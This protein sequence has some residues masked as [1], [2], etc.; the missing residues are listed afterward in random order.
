VRSI[1]LGFAFLVL[2]SSARTAHGQT[3]ELLGS[4]GPTIVDAGN[5]FTVGAAVSPGSRTSFV[6]S[7]ERTHLSSREGFNERSA[8][9]FRGGT[10]LLG[11]AE[12]RVAP[13]GRDRVGPYGLAGFAVGQSRPNVNPTFPN[14]VTNS[15]RAMFVGGG[16]LVPINERLTLFGDARMMFGA[17]GTDGIVGV[18]PVRAGVSWRF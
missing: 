13:L 11:T 12:L 15:V 18:A 6:F 8:F 1:T 16:L 17:E 4:A 5:S 2:L 7:F 9:S 10:F 3:F 14:P